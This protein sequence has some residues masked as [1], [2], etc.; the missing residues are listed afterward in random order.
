M[1]GAVIWWLAHENGYL[2]GG[3]IPVSCRLS[4]DLANYGLRQRLGQM[5]SS[6]VL[7]PAAAPL[8]AGC[9]RAQRYSPGETL[10]PS[11]SLSGCLGLVVQGQVAAVTGAKDATGQNADPELGQVYAEAMFLDAQANN[12]TLQALTL[13]EVW[14]V[15]L[16]DVAAL[17]DQQP[18]RPDTSVAM[19]RTEPPASRSRRWKRL[20]VCLVALGLGAILALALPPARQSLALVPMSL[21][22]WCSQ[23][24]Y[25][26][27]AEGSWRV[28]AAL[29]P[30]DADPIVALGI[31]HFERGNLEAAEES[32]QEA[33]ALAPNWSEIYNNLG[34]VYAGRGDH[35]L[36]IEAFLW[37]LEQEPG[38]AALEYNLGLS[39]QA[40]QRHGEALAHYR[41][42]LALGEPRTDILVNMAIAYYELK[43]PANAQLAAEEALHL[44]G[45]SAPAYTVLGDVSLERQRPDQ[46]LSFAEQ[47]ITLDAGY[48][49]AYV[50]MGLAHQAMRQPAKSRAAFE[51]ALYA[52]DDEWMSAKIQGYLDELPSWDAVP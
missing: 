39:L 27:C 16:A 41:S 2:W 18:R 10:L 29:A 13:C 25:D 17:V 42:A 47:A 22:Q 36:A 44:G 5:N 37:G 38:S 46:A 43:Q 28:A 4:P 19:Q 20:G 23:Q 12:A 24:G 35:E 7:G 51:Q 45:P 3:D 11:G 30:A 52:T 21:G 8:L 9:V 26:R 31:L 33:R 6:W 48:A 50:T 32:F 15:R 49:Q 14:F 1:I 40:L 34:A